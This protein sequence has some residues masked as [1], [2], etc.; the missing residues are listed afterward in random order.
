M[1]TEEIFA[2][3][4]PD[5]S[6]WS[7][8]AK[9]VLFAHLNSTP[10]AAVSS[11]VALDISWCPKPQE[12]TALILDLP[13]AQGV[14][15]ALELAKQ[16]YRP[17]PLYNAVP[18]PSAELATLLRGHNRLAAVDILPIISALR[19]GAEQ[20]A[21]TAIPPNAPPAFLLDSNRQGSQRGLLP[22]D[23]DNR[24]ICFTTDFPSGNFLLA[25]GIQNVLLVQPTLRAPQSDLA[26]PLLRWQEAGLSLKRMGLDLA[27]PP[28]PLEV[29]RP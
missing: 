1:N 20:L 11:E 23:F 26:H 9:P 12:Q 29:P 6:L 4:V 17:V 16:G 24:S 25:Q 22:N 27:G 14:L 28:M 10:H 7:P 5:N 13:S 21:A 18:L 19:A 8:W 3:W 2:A 15:V